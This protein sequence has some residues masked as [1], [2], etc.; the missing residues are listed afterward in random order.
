MKSCFVEPFNVLKGKGEHIMQNWLYHCSSKRQ[1]WQLNLCFVHSHSLCLSISLNELFRLQSP[2]YVTKKC[3]FRLVLWNWCVEYP[4]VQCFSD[5]SMLLTLPS[6]IKEACQ[7]KNENQHK[8]P[9][10]QYH[11]WLGALL[12]LAFELSYCGLQVG[13]EDSGRTLWYFKDAL[14]L[15]ADLGATLPYFFHAGE[16]GEWT[17]SIINYKTRASSLRFLNV[18]FYS[19]CVCV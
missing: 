13:R 8:S 15:P 10:N 5:Q 18:C 6:D 17:K 4:A 1:F 9:L 19:T 14:S 16:T 3:M 7:R 2:Y 12:H 11:C